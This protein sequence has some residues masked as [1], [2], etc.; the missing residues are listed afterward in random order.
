MASIRNKKAKKLN[1]SQVASN[2]NSKIPTINLDGELDGLSE[3]ARALIT[4]LVVKVQAVIIDTLKEKEAK[5][6][7]LE[8]KVT[9]LD[10]EVSKLNNEVS[11]L[12]KQGNINEE[13]IQKCNQERFK[14]V[15]IVSGDALP[16]ATPDENVE[17]V[18]AK[19]L[20]DELDLE[21]PTSAFLNAHRFKVRPNANRDQ[22]PVICL[23]LNPEVKNNIL[24]ACIEKRKK[25]FINEFMSPHYN[26]LF[27]KCMKIRHDHPNLI[28]KC[29]FRNGAICLKKTSDGPV[30]KVHSNEG[31]NKFLESS[32]S[33]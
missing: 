25:I 27:Q 31:L 9:T 1:D 16:A 2:S 28:N 17:S 8:K 32:N 33:D 22:K 21:I 13:T 24:D 18:L 4:T 11:E 5:I 26:A 7:F 12:Q 20:K 19:S 30:S 10:N 23:R 15:F 3:D 14:D 29:N 6:T